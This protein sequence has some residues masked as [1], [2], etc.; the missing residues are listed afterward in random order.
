MQI[1][2]TIFQKNHLFSFLVARIISST[3]FISNRFFGNFH[4][5]SIKFNVHGT[6]FSS[7]LVSMRFFFSFSLLIFNSFKFRKVHFCSQFLGQTFWSRNT[8]NAWKTTSTFLGKTFWNAISTRSRTIFLWCIWI[9]NYIIAR[10]NS[11]RW[12]F[13]YIL[14][15]PWS[16]TTWTCIVPK[17]LFANAR[18]K[19]TETKI[20][21]LYH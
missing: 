3:H 19:R 7:L 11:L 16:D 12:W 17:L 2:I 10:V 6:L 8:R 21:S 20:N 13:T 1:F 9:F 14:T 18:K 15:W 4:E 5:Q